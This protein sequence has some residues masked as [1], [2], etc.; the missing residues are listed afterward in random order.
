MV[1]SLKNHQ[2]K[3]IQEE[4][5]LQEFYQNE[6]HN[7]NDHLQDTLPSIIMEVENGSLEYESS[8]QHRQFPLPCWGKS[9]LFW[10][11][12]N[13]TNQLLPVSIC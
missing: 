12:L 2:Q 5:R 3:Q 9:S 10:W 4:N 1:P 7:F 11:L 6:N 13:G 8:L